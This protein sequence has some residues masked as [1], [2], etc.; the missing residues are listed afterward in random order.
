MPVKKPVDKKKVSTN[1][2]DPLSVA[3]KK[4]NSFSSSSLLSSYLSDIN[5]EEGLSKE[6]ENRLFERYKRGDMRARDKLIRGNLRFVFLM[7]RRLGGL[8]IEDLINEGNNG[9]LEAMKRYDGSKECRFISYAVWWVRQAALKAISEQKC[10]FHIPLNMQCRMAKINTVRN[11]LN[12]KLGRNPSVEEIAE[13]LKI[14]TAKV[15]EAMAFSKKTFHSVDNSILCSH[16]RKEFKTFFKELSKTELAVVT[17]LYVHNE[18]L[19]DI[20][21]K[22]N[23]PLTRISQLHKQALTKIKNSPEANRLRRYLNENM[24]QDF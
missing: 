17:S 13:E 10:S 6:E 3:E 9:L 8:P 16:F 7:V 14:S 18:T 4:M 19:D 24:Q 11:R 1:T 12:Q 5:N 21:R 23:L 15:S 2:V 20:A 22:L